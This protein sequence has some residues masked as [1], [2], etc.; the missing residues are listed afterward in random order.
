MK[1]GKQ[2]KDVKASAEDFT[3]AKYLYEAH[4]PKEKK[5]LMKI[6]KSLAKCFFKQNKKRETILHLL[7]TCLKMEPS[8][9]NVSFIRTCYYTVL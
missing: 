2:S 4:F 7:D 9:Y 6:N 5:R 8:F 3:I 1:F